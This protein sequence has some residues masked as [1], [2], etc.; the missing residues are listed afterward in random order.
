LVAVGYEAIQVLGRDPFQ[1]NID[2]AVRPFSTLGQSTALAQYLTSLALGALTCAIVVDRARVSLRATILMCAG[3]LLIGSAATGTRSALIGVATGSAALLAL[4]WVLHP[5][6]RAR[7]VSLLGAG[8]S[9]AV[10]GGLALLT[11]IG[12]R[13]ASTL[14]SSDAPD[15]EEAVNQFEPSTAGRLA[16]YE[17]GARMVIERP[18]LGYGPDSFV[19]GVPRY[20]PEQAPAL[21]RQSLATSAHSWII[22]V[23]STG[24]L[25]GLL[26][27]VAIAATALIL[28]LRS[29]F[30]PAAMV[31]A[32]VMCAFL[33]TGLTS[34]NELGTDWIFWS[35]AGVVAAA[36]RPSAR[37]PHPVE[38]STRSAKRRAVVHAS[39]VQRVG[40]LVFVGVA[41]IVALSS[42]TAVDASRAARASADSRQLGK[43]SQAIDL[44][45]RATRSDGGRANY[46]DA[47]GLAYIAAG[48]WKEASSAFD[49]ARQIA[50]YDVRYV[51]D[52]TQ[53]QLLLA[54]SGDAEARARAIRLADEVVR[55]DPNNP[56]PHLTR[57]VAMQATGNLPE[58]LNSVERAI[59]LDPGSTNTNLYVTAV[60]VMSSSG[61]PADA[62]LTARQGIA[63]FGLT[64][65]SMPIRVELARALVANGQL[66]D[67][68]AE[69]ET[70][71]SI[72]PGDV[73][74]SRLRDEIRATLAK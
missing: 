9:I 68:L 61:R 15:D 64:N 48:R 59:A 1:W 17:I 41:L 33:G 65:A 72:Q 21:I 35:S 19:V 34:V 27:F 12:A 11:P 4:L 45:L 37:L 73:A 26:C 70:A 24:G 66:I 8:A 25:V 67:A 13:L 40:P 58:A 43:D 54:N 3:I 20:R 57:A 71:L 30:Q 52:L 53:A 23:A 49:R 60:Q 74:A 2:T 28:A 46:W 5:N 44:G 6:P 7:R 10:L 39:M 36:T 50:P 42:W 56:R 69:L 32:V 63:V 31:G 62:V 14:Q 51:G 22:Q 18:V 55:I 38:R 47:L 16:L 29:G